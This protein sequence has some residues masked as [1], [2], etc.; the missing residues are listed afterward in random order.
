MKIPNYGNP[1]DKLPKFCK[2]HSSEG[3]INIKSKRCDEPN[4]KKQP[5]YGNP[6]DK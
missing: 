3:M 5:A 6:G 2:D 1:G 4:C